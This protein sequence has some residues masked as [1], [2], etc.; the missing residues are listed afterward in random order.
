[1]K[2]EEIARYMAELIERDTARSV[3]VYSDGDADGYPV[4][5]EHCPC[6]GY[7]FDGTTPNFCPDCGLRVSFKEVSE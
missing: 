6:C 3:D 7:D 2:R 5:E 1:M 4:W